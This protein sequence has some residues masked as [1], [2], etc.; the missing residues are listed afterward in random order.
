MDHLLIETSDSGVTTLTLNRPDR[1]NALDAGLMRSLRHAV[2]DAA[3]DSATRCLI[4]T[5]AGGNFCSGGDV[6]AIKDA[7]K[8]RESDRERGVSSKKTS[9]EN[10]TQWLRKNVETARLLHEMP[11]PTIAMIEGACAGAGMSLAAACDFRFSAD[12]AKFVTT[13]VPNG[14]SGDYGGSW[15]WTRI[16]GSAKARQLYLLDEK[17]DALQALEFG[18]VDKVFPAAELH[19]ST[20]EIADRLAGYPGSG[21][22]YAK[23]NLNAAPSETFSMAL[24][25]ESQ[26]MLLSRNA[27]MDA[28]RAAK[29]RD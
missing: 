16:L 28:M 25:R 21:L 15:L 17:R 11:K 13:F 24:D 5:G 20:R 7:A 4:L 9:L 12:V 19:T 10:R 3:T 26:N 18:L 2:A 27:L 29:N 22:A 14:I 6:R 1:L 23:A 8:N